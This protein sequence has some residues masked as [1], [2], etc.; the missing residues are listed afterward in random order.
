VNAVG[1]SNANAPLLQ[2]SGWMLE[3]LAV[4]VFGGMW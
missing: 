1:E 2:M 4:G 3:F